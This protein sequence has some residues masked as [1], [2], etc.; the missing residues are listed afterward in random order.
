M[1]GPIDVRF[2]AGGSED[3][4]R[5]YSIN[6][7]ASSSEICNSSDPQESFVV[8]TPVLSR[9]LWEAIDTEGRDLAQIKR[10]YLSFKSHIYVT[11]RDGK[12]REFTINKP[13]SVMDMYQVYCGDELVFHVRDHLSSYNLE[14]FEPKKIQTPERSSGSP[15]DVEIDLNDAP[16]QSDEEEPEPSVV[17]LEEQVG[18]MVAQVSS[19]F[20]SGV[21]L[22]ASPNVDALLCG[23]VFLCIRS[24]RNGQ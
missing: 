24:A 21:F 1:V 18:N 4:P 2:A 8:K 20:C 14:F 9:S 7:G 16:A 17:D 13:G 15:S 6:C 19:S 3:E 22:R 11:S 10:K 5:V 23:L 12:R